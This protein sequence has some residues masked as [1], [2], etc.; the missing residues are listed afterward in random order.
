MKRPAAYLA[1]AALLVA[2]AIGLGFV[3]SIHILSGQVL[4]NRAHGELLQQMLCTIVH[5]DHLI[6]KGC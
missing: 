2:A 6:A 4:G 1:F 3:I 5:H